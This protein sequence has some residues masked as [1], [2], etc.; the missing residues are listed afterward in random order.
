MIADVGKAEARRDRDRARTGGKERCLG[1]AKAAATFERDASRI[2]VIMRVG[3]VRIVTDRI[4][5]RIIEPNG[6]IDRR[7]GVADA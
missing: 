7:F 4:A 5:N 3:L 2:G 1:D 6:L